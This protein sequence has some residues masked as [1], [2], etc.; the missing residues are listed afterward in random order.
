V[1]ATCATISAV[2]Q[3]PHLHLDVEG[4]TRDLDDPALDAAIAADRARAT[5]LHVPSVGQ[6]GRGSGMW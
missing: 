4:F 2:P 5:L 6:P 1:T 3:P